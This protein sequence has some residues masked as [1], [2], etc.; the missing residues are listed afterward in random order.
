MITEFMEESLTLLQDGLGLELKDLASFA[1]NIAIHKTET[2]SDLTEKIQQWQDLDMQLYRH[3]NETLWKK[4]EAF[5]RERMNK[6]IEGLRAMNHRLTSECVASHSATE[7]DIGVQYREW[8]PKGVK[9]KAIKLFQNA[10]QL[11]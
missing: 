11:W 5:G 10:S 6:R 3:F 1:K 7:G 2:S 4:I 8:V 9:L